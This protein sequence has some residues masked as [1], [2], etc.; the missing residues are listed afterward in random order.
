[1]QWQLVPRDADRIEAIGEVGIVRAFQYTRSRGHPMSTE[2]TAR[3]QTLAE[4]KSVASAERFAT[5]QGSSDS[6][7]DHCYDKLLHVSGLGSGSAVLQREADTRVRVIEELC[8]SYGRTGQVDISA[9][10]AM[11]Q[12]LCEKI[13]REAAME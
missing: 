2:S 13:E 8:L 7:I 6:L 9:L 1:M 12:R 10:E 11:E 3:P 5:Y 4:L